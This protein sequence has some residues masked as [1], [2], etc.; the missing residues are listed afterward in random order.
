MATMSKT[1]KAVIA[2]V[3][4]FGYWYVVDNRN[5]YGGHN[6][7]WMRDYTPE[8]QEEAPKGLSRDSIPEART[9][10]NSVGT[11]GTQSRTPKMR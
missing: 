1:R 9:T 4:S 3:A 6:S 8:M 7:Y 5:P 2:W 10:F 11:T